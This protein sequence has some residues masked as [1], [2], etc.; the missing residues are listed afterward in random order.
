M[1]KSFKCKETNKIFNREYA[2]KLPN[3]IQKVAFRKLRMINRTYIIN[4]MKMPPGNRL[5]LLHGDREC[6]YNKKII[7]PPT[8]KPDFKIGKKG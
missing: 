5:D 3:N 8:P 2:K 4:D 7:N 1:I 6:Q